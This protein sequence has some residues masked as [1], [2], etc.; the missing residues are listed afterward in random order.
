[1]LGMA[2]DIDT[3]SP[4][5]QLDFRFMEAVAWKRVLLYIQENFRTELSYTSQDRQDTAV[6]HGAMKRKT[7]K[8][9]RINLLCTYLLPTDGR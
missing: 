6:K 7:L 1:M 5:S 2:K 9:L 8:L 3:F 4:N